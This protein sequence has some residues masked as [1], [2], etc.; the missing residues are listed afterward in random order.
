MAVYA[1]V[2]LAFV[3]Q[4]LLCLFVRRRILRLMPLLL[5]VLLA[6]VILIAFFVA[7]DLW[8]KI[9]LL[10]AMSLPILYAASTALAWLVYGVIRLLGRHRRKCATPDGE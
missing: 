5:S 10:F 3:V 1:T 4:L 6:L 7:S 8:D 9:G 2:A